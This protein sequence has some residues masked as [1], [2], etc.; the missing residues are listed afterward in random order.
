MDDGWIELDSITGG[1][2]PYN[3]LLN[4][5]GIAWTQQN[6]YIDSIP[7]GLYS[8]SVYDAN[9]CLQNN[10]I[11]ILTLDES[12]EDCIRIPAAFSPNGDGFNDLWQIDHLELYRRVLIQIYNRWGQLLYEAGWN[13]ELWD[14]KYNGNPVPT[15][16]YIYYINLGTNSKKPLTG[17][18]TIIR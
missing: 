9:H 4:G 10:D 15:G 2:P 13:D 17:T 3:L 5:G 18:V 14:G 1:T 7:S 12:D 16:A 6:I 11:I 8:I